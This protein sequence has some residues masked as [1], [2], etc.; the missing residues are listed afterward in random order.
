MEN[1][2]IDEYAY[3]F[4]SHNVKIKQTRQALL[5]LHHITLNPTTLR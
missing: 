4:K 1:I 5:R 2:Y 3:H